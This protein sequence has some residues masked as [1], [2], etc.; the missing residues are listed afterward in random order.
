MRFVE[1][2]ELQLEEGPCFDAFRTQAPVICASAGITSALQPALVQTAA[3]VAAAVVGSDG[4]VAA[5]EFQIV[6][7]P[8]D[9]VLTGESNEDPVT[10]TL[11]T[12]LRELGRL[13][14]R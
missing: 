8:G 6:A 9:V 2:M 11:T 5:S 4:Q 14:G 1:L 3:G 13:K 10:D 12:V 7:A